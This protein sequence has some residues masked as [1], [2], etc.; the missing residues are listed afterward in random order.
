MSAP[1]W[2]R[3]FLHACVP[4][5]REEDVLGDLEELHAR[6]VIR[7]GAPAAWIS[8]SAEALA[9][10]FAF[11][12][13][14][15][16]P[17]ERPAWLTWTEV[18]LALRLARKQ[19]FLNATVIVA[20]AVGIGLSGVAYTF[21]SAFLFAEMPLPAGSR[22]VRVTA[23]SGADGS[24]VT[25]TRGQ[26]EAL[27]GAAGDFEYLG[28][29]A[30]G[31]VNILDEAAGVEALAGVR[32]LPDAFRVLPYRP[33]VGRTLVPGDG[34][35][36]EPPVAVLGEEIWER[37]FGRDASV[38]GR[39]V[40]LGGVRTEVVGVLPAEAGFPN[41]PDVWLPFTVADL[42]DDTSVVGATVTFFG[43]LREGVPIE[44]ASARLAALAAGLEHA[45]SAPP[46]R[47]GVASYTD[48]PESG[49][50][51]LMMGGLVSVV[52]M[53]LLVIAANV[54]NL[55]SARTSGRTSEL[56]V[57]TAL[58]ASRARLVGQL[59]LEVAVLGAAAAALGWL[60]M[61][62]AMRWIASLADE[63]PFWVA[64][65]TPG[66]P[67]A[68]FVATV[69]LLVC[70]VAGVVPALRATRRDPGLVLR[71]SG[72]GSGGQG[73]ALA[74]TAMSVLQVAI[75]VGL[76]GA[77]V[78]TAKGFAGYARTPV[79]VPAA[80]I[81]TTGVSL[82]G[83]DDLAA[84]NARYAAIDDAV[85][86]VPGVTGA[87]FATQ[88]P[89]LDAPAPAVVVDPVPGE[90][91]AVP[92]PAPRVEA[93]A[94]FLEALGAT[95]I[96]GRLLEAGDF[97]PGAPRVAVVNVSFVRDF[98][99]G[100]NAVGRR[101]RIPAEG[102]ADGAEAPWHEIV[103]VVKDMGLS[104]GDPSFAGG[105]YVPLRGGGWVRLVARVSGDPLA[106]PPL[107][108]GAVAAVDPKLML[109]RI[110]TLEAAAADNVTALGTIGAGLGALGAVA[111]L[112]SLVSIYALVSMTVSRRFGE[113]GVRVALGATR[114]DV[115]RA[116]VGRALVQT[117]AGAVLG[118]G[119]GLALLQAD[120]LFVFR[121]PG[122]D[123]WTLPGAALLMVVAAGVAGWVPTR[124]AL[125]IRPADALR[126]E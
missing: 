41:R 30:D 3:A 51:F 57:R 90:G 9:V 99:G 105:Y 76:M 28:V 24:P 22:F 32:L 119:L 96:A 23:R 66:L 77:A 89:R 104:V 117:C 38:V 53:V 108:R 4:Q 17:G 71:A 27:E 7:R 121:V 118:I 124:R 102:V 1:R 39:T 73:F 29:M 80:E 59:S 70:A 64:D 67:A 56:A 86:A 2:A 103:G 16:R 19:P 114:V 79:D 120:G 54:G 106:Y 97:L 45:P 100:R 49:L 65:F 123:P 93:R 37:R 11:L 69:T 14:R 52:V 94:G 126:S 63:L 10:G 82:E 101:L 13:H 116:I 113:I 60:A 68:A 15:A 48:F 20:L 5:D 110:E 78:V 112:L 40:D 84:L 47:V 42:P 8:T 33:L 34:A 107:L 91:E 26:F 83:I 115:L 21:A 62:A 125:A 31:R 18:R 122:S 72:R 35:P 50:V 44:S 12:L 87:G 85:R 109:G 75:S 55:V 61:G 92:R 81:L 36:G 6:R 25:F 95:P 111:L 43:V 88:I 46:L 98:L 58:G 74:G